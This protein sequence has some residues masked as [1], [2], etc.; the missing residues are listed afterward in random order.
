MTRKYQEDKGAV[1]QLTSFY[2]STAKGLLS[3]GLVRKAVPALGELGTGG[4][5]HIVRD[6]L[7]AD[8]TLTRQEAILR[9]IRTPLGKSFASL[10]RHPFAHLPYPEAIAKTH[11]LGGTWCSEQLQRFVDIEKGWVE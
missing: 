11:A 7:D 1:V 5:E 4:F 2:G 9:A 6:E 10:T 3:K 8:A